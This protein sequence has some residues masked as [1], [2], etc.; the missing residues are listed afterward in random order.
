VLH[1][2]IRKEKKSWG[3]AQ[4]VELLPAMQSQGPE[5]KHQHHQKTKGK[6]KKKFCT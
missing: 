5:F 3:V 4:E 6:E 2:S 1:N